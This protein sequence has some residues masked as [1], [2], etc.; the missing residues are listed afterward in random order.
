MTT[1]R[2]G[3][4][5]GVSVTGPAMGPELTFGRTLADYY[6]STNGVPTNAVR[7]GIIKC[8]YGGTTLITDWAAN[9]NSTTNGDGV[10]YAAFQKVAADGLARLV[11]DHPNATIELDGMIW[12][13][14]ESDINLAS[15]QTGKTPVPAAATGYDTNLVR[16]INDVRLTFGARFPYGTN[17]PFFLSRISTNQTAY[18]YPTN[19]NYPF[20]LMVRSKQASVAASLTNVFMIDTDGSGFSVGTIAAQTGVYYGRQHFDTQ[21]QQALG[22]AFAKALMAALPRPKLEM[23]VKTDAGW[24]LSFAGDSGINYFLE[25]ATDIDGPWVSVTNIAFSTATSSNLLD[26]GPLANSAFYRVRHN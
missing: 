9:G 20:Y 4:S 26:S 17:L 3:G 23:P 2:P 22:T 24:M 13:Q 19:L 25:R 18:S 14:G 15:G 12:V 10:F 11:Q 8:A 7:V 1:L 5:Q 6:A 16:F 21:G